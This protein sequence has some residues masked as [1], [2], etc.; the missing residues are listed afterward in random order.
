MDL[1]ITEGPM[2]DATTQSA[3]SESP[4]DVALRL[5]QA[6]ASET[7]EEDI[8][9]ELGMEIL[10]EKCELL[11]EVANSFLLAAAFESVARE[12]DTTDGQA[13]AD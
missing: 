8:M 6:L 13:S 3:A 2:T 10:R 11:V 1:D 9:E 12:A 5:F 7:F 4:E